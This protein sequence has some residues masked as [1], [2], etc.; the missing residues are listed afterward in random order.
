MQQG[1]WPGM[2]YDG[3]FFGLIPSPAVRVLLR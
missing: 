2:E 1:W 3:M